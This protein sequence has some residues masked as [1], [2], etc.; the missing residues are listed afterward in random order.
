MWQDK[1]L[2]KKIVAVAFIVLMIFVM[3]GCEKKEES[4]EES[5][6]RIDKK[7]KIN[8]SI[9]ESFNKDY[10]DANEL[11]MVFN[12]AIDSYNATI[13]SEASR[14]ES[15]KVEN[16]KV[17]A[18][19]SYD[20]C[21]AY[22]GVQGSTL[23]V[24]TISDAVEAGY[25]MDVTLK[26]TE[27]GDKISRVQIMGMKDKHIIILDEAV[28]VRVYEPI[29]YV[30]ANVEVV[31]EKEARVTSEYGAGLAYIVLKK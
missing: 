27:A 4:F 10:Y 30:S 14:L 1:D 31:S 22:E 5:I 11:S 2:K 23:F 19:L 3:A 26:G 13:G 7:G 15:L 24:G 12:A 16:G 8:E 25:S 29:A 17:Y 18:S 9:V 21:N 6:I 28:K 20:D